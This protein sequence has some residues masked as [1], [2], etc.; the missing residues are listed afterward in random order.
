MYMINMM[1]CQWWCILTYCNLVKPYDDLDLDQ[2]W[3]D[4]GLLPDGTWTKVDLSSKVLCDIHMRAISQ[5]VLMNLIRSF[6]SKITLL[7]LLP[8]LLG[9]SELTHCGLMTPANLVT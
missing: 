3:L 1:I 5:E 4:N 6:C 9:A 8:H 2:H 7:K